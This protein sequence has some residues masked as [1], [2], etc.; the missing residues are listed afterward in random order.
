[1]GGILLIL[2]FLINE[3]YE[4]DQLGAGFNFA[5]VTGAAMIAVFM[6]SFYLFYSKG[7]RRN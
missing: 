6:A 5:Y 7:G 2:T 4:E 3:Y 1:M